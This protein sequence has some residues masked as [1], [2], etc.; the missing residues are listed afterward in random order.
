MKKSDIERL[1]ELEQEKLKR[2]HGRTFEEGEF[3]LTALDYNDEIIIIRSRIREIS[4]SGIIV[5]TNPDRADRDG[6]LYQL[7][8]LMCLKMVIFTHDKTEEEVLELLEILEE[9]EGAEKDLFYQV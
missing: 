3:H 9:P 1:L 8:D 2:I 6:E 7:I 5:V 4:D